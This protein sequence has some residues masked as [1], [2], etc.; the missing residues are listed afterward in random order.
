MQYPAEYKAVAQQE[1]GRLHIFAQFF[2]I[3]GKDDQ[4]LMPPEDALR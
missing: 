2:K 3:A 4:Q 1:M